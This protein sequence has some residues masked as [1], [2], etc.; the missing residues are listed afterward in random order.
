M[1]A[2]NRTRKNGMNDEVG[3]YLEEVRD[4][5]LLVPAGHKREDVLQLGYGSDVEPLP[6]KKSDGKDE[7][8]QEE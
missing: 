8:E 4:D 1:D 6:Q 7:D 3:A 5:M 2:E